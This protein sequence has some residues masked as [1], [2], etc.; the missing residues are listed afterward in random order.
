MHQVQHVYGIPNID[1]R[2]SMETLIIF[3]TVSQESA[4]KFKVSR[5]LVR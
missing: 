3:A 4:L 5:E 2:I 1:S